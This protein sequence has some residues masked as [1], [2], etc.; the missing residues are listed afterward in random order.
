MSGW[1]YRTAAGYSAIARDATTVYCPFLPG[2]QSG[3][4]Q[5]QY[6]SS[7]LSA[8]DVAN[9]RSMGAQTLNTWVHY[10]IVRSDNT[11][12]TFRNGTQIDTWTSTLALARDFNL[13]AL[14]RS[15]DFRKLH[16][17]Y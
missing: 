17:L 13:L 7:N 4:N 12:Y 6:M 10:A 14:G 5:V 11:F 16:R 2:Y 8:W 9:A 3:G 1:E 15:A